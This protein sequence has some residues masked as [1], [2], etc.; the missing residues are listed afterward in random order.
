MCN[1]P[2]A[3]LLPWVTAQTVWMFRLFSLPDCCKGRRDAGNPTLHS[4]QLSRRKLKWNVCTHILGWGKSPDSYF[5][6]FT[7]IHKWSASDCFETVFGQRCS[8]QPPLARSSLFF[9]CLSWLITRN[10]LLV[11]INAPVQIA[12]LQRKITLTTQ[13]VSYTSLVLID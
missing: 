1:R 8:F 5:Q 10:C 6:K 13:N 7:E 11:N 4:D 12:C 3:I 9:F 2:K